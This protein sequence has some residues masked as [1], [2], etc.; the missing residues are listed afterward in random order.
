[1]NIDFFH[2]FS[3]RARQVQKIWV[4][5]EYPSH[6][7][8]MWNAFEGKIVSN[9]LYETFFI[10]TL[11]NNFVLY[12]WYSAEPILMTWRTFFH[13][14][15]LAYFM[16]WAIQIHWFQQFS[17]ELQQLPVSVIHS[18]MPFMSFRSRLELFVFWF[19]LV[20]QFI[21]PSWV[22]FISYEFKFGFLQEGI[23]EM[24]V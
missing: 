11:I 20:L 5:K 12:L 2:S 17:S 23:L 3:F 16:Y 7:T 4:E 21:W 1:M 18:F 8:I 6:Q 9:W 24:Q 10:N 15:Q 22:S 13:T 19:I 14:A